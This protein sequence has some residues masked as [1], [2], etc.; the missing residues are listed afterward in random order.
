M[1][2]QGREIVPFQASLPA[3]RRCLELVP[4][5]NKGSALDEVD[6]LFT[7]GNSLGNIGHHVDAIVVWDE[8]VG[9]FGDDTNSD[10]R[11]WVACAICH[12]GDSLKELGQ[13]EAAIAAYDEVVERFGDDIEPRASV[14]VAM[15]QIELGLLSR[16]RFNMGVSLWDRGQYRDAIAVFNK[17]VELFGETT[18]P[19]V[20]VVVAKALINNGLGL[21]QQGR[22]HD[23]ITLFD[24]V[25]RRFGDAT[26]PAVRELAA[27]AVANKNLTLWHLERP[28][29]VMPAFGEMVL[30]RLG[31]VTELSVRGSV[32]SAQPERARRNKRAQREEG[33]GAAP[34]TNG[35]DAVD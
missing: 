30:E 3:V 11:S 32:G 2:D 35:P 27:K 19:A 24:E 26:E 14:W 12:K 15:A 6:A 5:L 21:W 17:V 10:V 34:E 28:R 18:G 16:S 1:S 20:R 9:R 31:E 13:H 8:V 29:G 25:V 4:S 33:T 23:A 7:K 22:R